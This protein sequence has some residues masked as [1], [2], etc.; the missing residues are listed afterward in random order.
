MSSDAVLLGPL[1]K[2]KVNG[3][4]FGVVRGRLR[5]SS[6]RLEKTDSGDFVRSPAI[7]GDPAAGIPAI[8]AT[9]YHFKNFTSTLY[10]VEVTITMQRQSNVPPHNERRYRIRALST[11]DLKISP[12]GSFLADRTYQ[13]DRFLVENFDAGLAVT[14]SEP[15]SFEFSGVATSFSRVINGIVTPCGTILLPGDI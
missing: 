14:G 1:A 2:V 7:P 11:I 6:T 15:Q 8:P 4:R 10:M 9:I 3:Q 12:D 5:V 13:M